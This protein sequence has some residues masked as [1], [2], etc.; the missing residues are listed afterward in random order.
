MALISVIRVRGNRQSKS[1]NLPFFCW[2][3]MRFFGKKLMK[4]VKLNRVAGPFND[5]PFEN[6][7]QSPIGLVPKD[8]GMQ[9]R[10]IFHLSFEFPD[11]HSLNF[12]TPKHR[13]SMTYNDLDDA[14]K[15]CLG[16]L[17]LY[18]G[19]NF[20]LFTPKSDA[21]SAF[22]LVPLSPESW[23]WVVMKA[24]D[25]VARVWKFFVDKC[26]P[27]GASISCALFQEF[28]DALA[29][30]GQAQSQSTKFLLIYHFQITWMISCFWQGLSSCAIGYS[31]LSS[32]YVISWGFPISDEKKLSGASPMMVFLGILMDGIRFTLSVLEDKRLKAIYLL[33]QFL[34]KCKVTVKDL[35]GLC[36]YLNFICRAIHPGHPF[37]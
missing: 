12:H 15:K 28:S 14:V 23:K 30:F 7:I 27:F 22:R 32:I 35:Q 16:L 31:L 34:A 3:I 25:P 36:G 13:C 24:L 11:G 18:Q 29:F 21:K 20:H 5:I 37:L 17:R 10:L 26:L 1:R 6:F 2:K 9:T 33:D 19:E 4:E 8:K